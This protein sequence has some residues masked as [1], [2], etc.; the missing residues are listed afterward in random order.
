M[1][2]WCPTVNAAKRV[3]EITAASEIGPAILTTI[4][5]DL[6]GAFLPKPETEYFVAT[7]SSGGGASRDRINFVSSVMAYGPENDVEEPRFHS[8]N[9]VGYQLIESKKEQGLAILYRR[10][11]LFI[12]NDPLKGGRLT[13]LY[14]RVRSFSLRFLKARPGAATGTPRPRRAFPRPSRSS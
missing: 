9:E 1:A 5:A 7:K 6:E 12:D 13:E 4:R 2:S 8:V 10:E 14:D 3:E 11:D